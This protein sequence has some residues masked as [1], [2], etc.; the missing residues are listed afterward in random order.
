MTRFMCLS[1]QLR[2]L[3]ANARR[4]MS[5]C[6]AIPVPYRF[7]AIG[8]QHWRRSPSPGIAALSPAIV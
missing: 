4:P 7:R 3:I 6:S 2:R 5:N 1:V 8:S